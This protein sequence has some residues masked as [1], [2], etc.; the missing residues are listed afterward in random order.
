MIQFFGWLFHPRFVTAFRRI[1]FS[2]LFQFLYETLTHVPFGIA[3]FYESR[4]N[5]S[6]YHVVELSDAHPAFRDPV[7][8]CLNR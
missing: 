8:P 5:K 4:S 6:V 3:L 7:L 1:D 2:H